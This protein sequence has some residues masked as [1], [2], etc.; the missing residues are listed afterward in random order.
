MWSVEH[1]V[2]T[3]APVQAIWRRYRE[4]GTW[5]EWNGAVESVVLDGEFATGARGTLTPPNQGPLPF[6]VVAATENEGYVSETDIADTVTLRLTSRLVPLDGGGTRISHRAELDGPAA[7]HFARSFGPVLAAGVPRTLE[8]LAAT[9]ARDDGHPSKSALIVLTSTDE[10]GDTGRPT[11]AYVS[12]VAEAWK[13]Y[14][15]AGY[16]VEIAS[17]RGGRPPLEAVDQQDPVQRAFLDDPGAGASLADTCRPGDVDPRGYDVVFVA[18]GH[19]AVW[20]LPHDKDLA[21]LLRDAYENGAVVAAVCHGPAALLGVT[22][23]DG[24]F[25]VAGKQVAAFSN[26]EERAVGMTSVVPFLLADALRELG[27]RYGA[28]PSFMPHVA[29]DGRLVTGQNP[30]SATAVAEASITAALGT[31]PVTSPS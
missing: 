2:D 28:A 30:A 6:R 29:V 31:K 15:E 22:L 16:R 11:G 7:P 8:A 19:G 3:T 13:V 12:E 23:S 24:T 1:S 20:D 21:A 17:V 9:V 27:A 26:D 4:V 14:T 5:P 25:L 18:G 10:L